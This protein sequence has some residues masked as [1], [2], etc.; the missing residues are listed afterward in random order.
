MKKLLFLS[1]VFLLVS[2]CVPVDRFLQMNFHN[3]S[4][5]TI[6]VYPCSEQKEGEHTRIDPHKYYYIWGDESLDLMGEMYKEYGV[7]TLCWYV[8]DAATD[9]ILQQYFLG[10]D[11]MKNL[12]KN[13]FS[14]PPSPEMKNMKMWPPYGTYDEHGNRVK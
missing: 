7:D 10:L 8:R 14:F 2:G 4:D 6:V 11:D 1:V 5:K 13:Y 9:S 3:D 12:Y